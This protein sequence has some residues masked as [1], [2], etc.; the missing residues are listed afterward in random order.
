M[1][2]RRF[3]LS[4]SVVTAFLIAAP[5]PAAS[6][7]DE[8]KFG[9]AHH[10]IGVFGSSREDGIDLNAEIR[11]V[12]P[13]FLAPIFAPRPH[14]GVHANTAG[15]TSQVYFGLTWSFTLFRDVLSRGDG[16][17]I[18]GSLGGAVH[19]GKLDTERVDRKAL[20]SRILF[21]ESLELGYR[22][23]EVHSISVMLDHISNANLADRNEGLETLG[24]RYGLKF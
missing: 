3:A 22:F 1:N 7:V 24:I 13:A 14:L 18:D 23:A 20:G 12:S 16:F 8:V 4:V 19:N 10:D 2:L 11:F 21:R 5:A 17:F 6:L 15:D 9:V